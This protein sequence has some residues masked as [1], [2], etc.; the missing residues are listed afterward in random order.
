MKFLKDLVKENGH[1]L[2]HY[3]QEAKDGYMYM[4]PFDYSTIHGGTHDSFK[5]Y[6]YY[7]I[8]IPQDTAKRYIGI[9]DGFG[10]T[11]K[12]SGIYFVWGKQFAKA[13]N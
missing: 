5:Y 3:T 7:Y 11:L 2:I 13:V 8:E 4:T 1:N 10:N 12:K 6:N 9:K